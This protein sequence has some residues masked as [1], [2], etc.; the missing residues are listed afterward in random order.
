MET[1]NIVHGMRE[2]LELACMGQLDR[3]ALRALV[4]RL[5]ADLRVLEAAAWE[6]EEGSD[7]A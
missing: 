5:A 1:T 2:A 6:G 4:E 7:D 3:A